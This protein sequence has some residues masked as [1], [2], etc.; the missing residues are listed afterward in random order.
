V[1]PAPQLN[2]AHI[3][4]VDD[5]DDLVENLTEI[6]E[7]EGAR[8]TRAASASEALDRA[9]I[10]FDVA[11]VDIRLPDGTGL[12]LL[13]ALRA[14]GDA[15][16]EVLLIT[17]NASLDDAIE[18][19]GREA[20]A[21]VLKPFDPVDL[22]ATVSRALEKVRLQR[23]SRELERRARVAEKLAAVGTLSAGLAH[24]IRNPLNAASLQM[25]LLE[26]RLRRDG[27]DPKFL[28]PVLMVQREL[29]RLS[30]LVDDFLRFARPA[31]LYVRRI[32]ASA[33]VEY[34][35]ELLRPEARKLGIALTAEIP[36]E[37]LHIAG[38]RE[39]LQQVAINV[40]RNA[41]EALE[42]TGGNIIVTL[43]WG[44]DGMVRLSV[45]DDGP[46]I[47]EEIITRIFEPFFS[48]KPMGTGLG[49]AITHSIVQQHGG[50]IQITVDH[51]TQVEIMLP[52]SP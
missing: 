13:P 51:G 50:S 41:I 49:M 21:Y 42:S 14:A 2:D 7:D 4:L 35:V 44:P 33:L 19:I 28:D 20:Y 30:H 34:V 16:G 9:H 39:K 48:T 43:E 5:H 32:D 17:G 12:A 46:G 25:Q 26:R 45:R 3:L 24:E 18:A 37:P 29:D 11:L 22:L 47:P 31:D 36:S 15:H 1:T 23:K 40:V 8:V 38:D 10:G 27:N 52:S 6:L